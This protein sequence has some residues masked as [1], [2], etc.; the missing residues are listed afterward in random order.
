MFS[1]LLNLVSLQIY[2]FLSHDPLTMKQKCLGDIVIE[3]I[4]NYALTPK[5]MLMEWKGKN[6]WF[7]LFLDWSHVSNFI[8]LQYWKGKTSEIKLINPL[9]QILVILLKCNLLWPLLYSVFYPSSVSFLPIKTGIVL[10]FRMKNTWFGTRG[11]RKS[12]WD[13]AQ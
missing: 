5:P 2:A 7:M 1:C 10:Y 12:N 4:L 13:W 6:L 8:A 3:A 11:R 9:F